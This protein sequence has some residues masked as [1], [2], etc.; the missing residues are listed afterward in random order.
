[1]TPQTM[2]AIRAI[3]EVDGSV[4]ADARARILSFCQNPNA[5]QCAAGERGRAVKV[6]LTAREVASSLRI[7]L[8]TV[9]RM[10]ERGQ[11]HPARISSRFTRFRADEVDRLLD[12]SATV[13]PVP[14]NMPSSSSGPYDMS[15]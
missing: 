6:M 15:A 3:L 13:Q 9:W 8:R 12:L 1:M 2:R 4:S 7:T 11:L 5:N 10:V 14:S